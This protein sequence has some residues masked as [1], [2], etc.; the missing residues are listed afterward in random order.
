MPEAK[1]KYP[2]ELW[3][4][5]DEA[6]DKVPTILH[7]VL[8]DFAAL[9][10]A[11][12][13]LGVKFPGLPEA[14][15][16]ERSLSL[17]VAA[18]FLRRALNDLRAIW[19]LVSRG[20]PS[21]AA[22]VASS[23]W[24]NALVVACVAGHEDRAKLIVSTPDGEVPWKPAQLAKMYAEQDSAGLTDEQRVTN[25]LILYS[26]YNWLCRMK[27]PTVPSATHDALS[28]GLSTE[29]RYALGVFP[30][31]RPENVPVKQ[32][33]LITSV[34]RVEE[35][36]DGLLR[37]LPNDD[38]QS[39]ELSDFRF[40]FGLVKNS[41]SAI[42]DMLHRDNEVPMPFTTSLRFRDRANSRLKDSHFCS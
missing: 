33:L 40:R 34:L 12:Y 31:L 18:L 39:S 30:D 25:E 7:E 6:E 13:A 8:Y 16:L 11:I 5:L 21:Q 20:Y 41:S 3:D 9:F 35:A 42:V 4:L 19:L 36:I 23:L 24:E 22:C 17:R 2:E 29:G 14:K 26:F 38:P 10:R 1:A 28:A 27:H 32:L 37:G 15:A